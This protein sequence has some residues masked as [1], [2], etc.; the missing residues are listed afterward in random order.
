MKEKMIYCKPRYSQPN[1]QAPTGSH[2]SSPGVKTA[3]QSQCGATAALCRHHKASLTKSGGQT[4]VCL[5]E[6]HKAGGLSLGLQAAIASRVAVLLCFAPRTVELPCS[7]RGRQNLGTSSTAHCRWRPP[8]SNHGAPQQSTCK[9]LSMTHSST[10]TP[11]S[12][13]SQE[14]ASYSQLP[15]RLS[16]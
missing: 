14:A 16:N 7:I 13:M 12:R 8:C 9:P 11:P 2:Y 10:G 1:H 4:L 5:I 3:V 15:Q 6:L